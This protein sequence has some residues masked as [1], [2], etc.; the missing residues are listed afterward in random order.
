MSTGWSGIQKLY[1]QYRNRS[2]ARLG[3]IQNV[4]SVNLTDRRSAIR[5]PIAVT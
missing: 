3:I 4:P 2:N 5:I 1:E